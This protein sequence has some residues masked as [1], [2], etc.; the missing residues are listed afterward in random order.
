MSCM[1]MKAVMVMLQKKNCICMSVY[2]DR[3]IYIRVYS[4]VLCGVYYG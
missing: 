1:G 4:C 3:Y 2:M